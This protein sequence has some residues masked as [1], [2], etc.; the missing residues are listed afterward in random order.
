MSRTASL[1]VYIGNACSA[2]PSAEEVDLRAER[3]DEVVVGQGRELVELDLARVEV[4]RGDRRL[5]DRGVVLVVEEVAD[6]VADGRRLEQARRDLVQER[7]ERVV[8]VLVDEHDVDVGLVQLVRGTDPGEAAAENEDPRS[9]A[10]GGV[11][12]EAR[13]DP[14]LPRSRSR[15]HARA[16]RPAPSTEPIPTMS[17]WVMRLPLVAKTEGTPPYYVRKHSPSERVVNVW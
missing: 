5:V 13:P 9:L 12:H 4:D 16:G 2:A 11:R 3:E 6:R 7:L 15:R 1:S 14:R 10:T 8:V 17:E